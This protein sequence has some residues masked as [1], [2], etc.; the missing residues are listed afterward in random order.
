MKKNIL[1][2]IMV[3]FIQNTLAQDPL[4]ELNLSLETNLDIFID[5]KWFYVKDFKVKKI[6]GKEFEA[7][8]KF[9]DTIPYHREKEYIISNYFP[10]YIQDGNWCNV[11]GEYIQKGDI[12]K[13]HIY[14][15][16]QYGSENFNFKLYRSDGVLGD[17]K[18]LNGFCLLF[19]DLK[20]AKDF[21]SIAHK[22]QGTA[23]NSTPWLRTL[24]ESAKYHDQ[25]SKDLFE[26]ILNDFK[27]YD[28]KSWQV[29][30]NED[31]TKTTNLTI[32][33]KYPYIIISYTDIKITDLNYGN[34]FK[35]GTIVINIPI[36]DSRFEFGR[37]FSGAD[38][39]NIMCIYA[40]SGI[41][42]SYKGK[43]DIIESC[44]FYASKMICKNLLTKLRVFK[45]KV[46][47]EN[48]QG[49]YGFPCST[50]KLKSNKN[51]YGGKY[52]Q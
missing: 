5:G 15:N 28:I 18:V 10:Y 25:T 39:E 6:D 9:V 17:H 42:I 52:V 47:E 49:E 19:H 1:F 3:L 35:P 29:Y 20:K 13:I 22:L 2:I 46:L 33:Y 14:N 44:N 48:Y 16:Y 11:N 34:D 38:D 4:N 23:Y 43:K 32:K 12:R 7:N 27:Q 41:E 21:V 30:K 37:R 36:N 24:N 45:M 40:S 51:L 26:L 31:W 50:L 8:V